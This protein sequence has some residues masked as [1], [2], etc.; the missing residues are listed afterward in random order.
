MTKPASFAKLETFDDARKRVEA[1]AEAR[2]VEEIRAFEAAYSAWKAAE[3]ALY[4]PNRREDDDGR[5]DSFHAAERALLA[6]PAPRGYCL[7]QKW[8]ALDRIATFEAS[9][10]QLADNRVI[11]ALGAVK[12]DLLRLLS[13]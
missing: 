10:G 5:G 6:T 3:A 11:F 7:W 12:A 4:E 2:E 8:E 1:D 9:E 13:P